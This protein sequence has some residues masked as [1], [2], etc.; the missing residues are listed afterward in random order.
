MRPAYARFPMTA[1]F[2]A[3]GLGLL[4]LIYGS[5]RLPLYLCI[6]AYLLLALWP[7]FGPW[8]QTPDKPETAA[9]SVQPEAPIPTASVPS[10]AARQVGRMASELNQCLD[11][12]GPE[13]PAAEPSEAAAALRTLITGIRQLGQ[14]VGNSEAALQHAST[15]V[16]ALAAQ[17]SDSQAVLDGLAKRVEEIQQVAQVIQSIA[18]QTNLLA[19]NAAIEAARAG[20]HGRG[21]AVVA[22]EVRS[23]SGRT[24][25]ATEQVSRIINDVR[26]QSDEV[27][28]RIS[29]QLADLGEAGSQLEGTGA[30]LQA[31]GSG[32]AEIEAGLAEAH[33]HSV[34]DS[35]RLTEARQHWQD[36]NSAM[37]HGSMLA[38]QLEE[39]ACDLLTDPPQP[40]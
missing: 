40:G 16:L 31:I 21:F 10:H 13:V 18:S 34:E 25:E 32:L 11:D 8:R 1:L 7:W 39:A 14:R 5:E 3:I 38:R 26:Q 9:E 12:A 23:L 24:A 29:Q 28:A 19:L 36:L 17:G 33:H 2:H 35:C 27:V 20:E 6:P 22:D 37:Q 30:G 4:M 15:C